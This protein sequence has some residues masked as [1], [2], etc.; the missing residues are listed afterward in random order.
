MSA[1]LAMLGWFG[2]ACVASVASSSEAP[3]LAAEVRPLGW[4]AF[5]ACSPKGD[6]EIYAMRPDGSDVR[7]LSDSPDTDWSLVELPR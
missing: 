3:S 6:W 7:N 1:P 2:C 5:S 4:I